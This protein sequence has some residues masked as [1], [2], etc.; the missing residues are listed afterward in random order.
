VCVCVCVCVCELAW[1]TTFETYLQSLVYASARTWTLHSGFSFSTFSQT[2]KTASGFVIFWTITVKCQCYTV[3]WTRPTPQTYFI[4]DKGKH[5]LSFA[6][7]K[8]L[9]FVVSFF[10]TYNYICFLPPPVTVKGQLIAAV[11][12][13]VKCNSLVWFCLTCTKCG[14][15]YS[16]MALKEIRKSVVCVCWRSGLSPVWEHLKTERIA[17]AAAGHNL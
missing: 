6:L 5:G 12:T 10:F 15:M 1:K 4:F 13:Y 8:W 2:G 3:L 11:A 14:M 17:W 16:N 9:L 7:A